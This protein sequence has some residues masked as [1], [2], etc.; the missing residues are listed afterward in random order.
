MP[1]PVDTLR[2]DWP[3]PPGVCG[4][5]STR[6]FGDVKDEAV[7]Q[8]LRAALPS[9]PVWLRQ[10]HGT[11]VVDAATVAEGALPEADAAY[12]R[13]PG[14]VCCVMAAD[15][16]PVLLAACDGSVVGAAHAGW[17]GLGAGVI[18][19][20]IEAMRVP[21]ADVL[22]WLGPAIG[23]R[24]YEVGAEVREAYLAHDPRSGAA[25]LS[26]RRGHWMLDL[27]MVARQ[28]LAA[29]GVVSVY[30]GTHCTYTEAERFFSYRRDKSMQ[31]M[32]A[33][34]HV[35]PNGRV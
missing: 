3:S 28:R 23:P 27:Y 8:K 26:T 16:M 13:E 33:C 34:I 14:V 1:D 24:A 31:R 2:A 15:C 30:G 20:T 35:A 22:A 11:T 9:A 19:K 6:A 29:K 4:F 5:V 32:A 25:F 18:E 17:R 7:R 12:T 21:G 10:V